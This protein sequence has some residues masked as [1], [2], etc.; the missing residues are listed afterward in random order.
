MGGKALFRDFH[1]TTNAI[2][3]NLN[4]QTQGFDAWHQSTPKS[5]TNNFS[6]TP[7][8]DEE[9]G[10]SQ[11]DVRFNHMT[12]FVAH[13]VLDVLLDIQDGSSEYELALVPCIELNVEFK[14][15][16]AVGF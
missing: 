11:I 5:P 10:I 2:N 15:M 16:K 1:G 6:M 8:M 3:F 4:V 12:D 13:F 14:E 9:L 7:Q